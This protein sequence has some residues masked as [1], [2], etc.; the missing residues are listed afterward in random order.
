M[1][2]EKKICRRFRERFSS[3][4]DMTS[5]AKRESTAVRDES[6]EVFT[7]AGKKMVRISFRI[8][9]NHGMD[10]FKFSHNSDLFFIFL[11]F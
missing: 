6:L 8:L 11:T 4:R 1:G 10:G 3:L 7:H 5:C 2:G 9:R